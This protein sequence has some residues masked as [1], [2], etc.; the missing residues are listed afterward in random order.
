MSVLAGFPSQDFKLSS[1]SVSLRYRIISQILWYEADYFGAWR[2]I[3][4][5]A[6]NLVIRQ[7]MTFTNCA[8]QPNYSYS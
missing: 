2:D 3:S 8:K 6:Q 7:T 5:L 4:S 1:K